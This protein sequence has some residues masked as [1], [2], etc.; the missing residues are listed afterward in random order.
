MNYSDPL[1]DAIPFDIRI[2]ATLL[3]RSPKEECG[4]QNTLRLPRHAFSPRTLVIP[5]K[6]DSERFEGLYL[7][8]PVNEA[9]GVNT[10]I[11][12]SILYRTPQSGL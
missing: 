6:G 3:Y 2:G 11:G 4:P 8:T 7:H 5:D 9:V 12:A 1:D 10:N